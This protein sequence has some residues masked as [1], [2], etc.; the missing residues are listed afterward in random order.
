ML[1]VI[2]TG[3]RA[4]FGESCAVVTSC[5]P[6][7]G[8]LPAWRQNQNSLRPMK[9]IGYARVSTEDQNLA[10]QMVALQQAG[11]ERLFTDQGISGATFARPGLSAALDAAHAGDSLIVW[12]LDRLGRSLTH[13]VSLIDELGRRGIQFVSLTESINTTNSGGRLMLHM[14]AA[15]AEFERT[16]ISERTRAGMEAARARGAHV[17]RRCAMTSA[18]C[19][20][21]RELLLTC[22]VEDVARRYKVH[23]RTLMRLLRPPVPDKTPADRP[24]GG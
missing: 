6:V 8:Q 5:E 2:Q 16:L 17:G 14:M 18:Q 3:W 13:L 12:R 11:C 24:A 21:A 9:K 22:S 4:G 23:P 15:L 10:L 20:E 19:D 1:R 7:T